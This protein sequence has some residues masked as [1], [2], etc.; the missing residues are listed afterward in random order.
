MMKKGMVLLT[1][2]VLLA[3]YAVAQPGPGKSKNKRV[4]HC[5][6]T[7]GGVGVDAVFLSTGSGV[8]QEWQTRDDGTYQHVTFVPGDREMPEEECTG[9]GWFTWEPHAYPDEDPAGCVMDNLPMDSY[10][11]CIEDIMMD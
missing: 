11:V 4:E 2:L 1:A 7:G 3:A 8:V 10:W 5:S 6:F 9:N